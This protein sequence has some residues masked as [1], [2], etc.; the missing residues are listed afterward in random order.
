MTQKWEEA[1][2]ETETALTAKDAVDDGVEGRVYSLFCRFY[3]YSISF[4]SFAWEEFRIFFEVVQ[5]RLH[6]VE[7]VRCEDYSVAF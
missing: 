2:G 5:V 1:V 3:S 7:K 6:H 4:R